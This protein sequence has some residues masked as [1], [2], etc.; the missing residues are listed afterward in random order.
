MININFRCPTNTDMRGKW[1][2][3]LKN[4]CFMLDWTK[5][6]I[7]SKHFENRYFD[8]Q[9]RIKDTAIPTLFGAYAKVS[10]LCKFGKF[11]FCLA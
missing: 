1:L 6:K 5:S 10:F 7:C 4:K 9:R 8:A 11:R 3:V 2:K